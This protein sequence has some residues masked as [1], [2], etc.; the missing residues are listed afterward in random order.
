MLYRGHCFLHRAEVLGLL[1][2]WPE[3][4]DRGP[5]GL[6]SPGRSGQPRRP[7]RGACVI[8]GDL[9]RL[10]GDLDGAEAAYQ[11][12]SEHRP[13]PPAR[14]GAAATRP[15]AARR[16][17]RHDPSSPRR[18]PGPDRAGPPARR[19]TS[20]SCSP[21][22]TP[23][24]PRAAADEFRAMAAELG[25]PLLRAHAAARHRRRAAW[26]RATPSRRSSSCGGPSTS[27]TPSACAHDAARDPP[28]HRRRPATRSATTT[29]PRIESGAARAV[30]GVAR[31]VRDATTEASRPRAPDGLTRRELR[32]AP[33][34]SPE[35]RRTG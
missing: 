30:L 23:L 5:P 21:R 32:G 7:R 6:R 13:R 12:A 14:P 22:A 10:V 15:G 16:R 19:R 8:E 1:G 25:T 35:A 24:T 26:P 18:G 3:A 4:L 9:L 27:S 20:R 31:R 11:R 17:R 34:S 33:A 29:P 2:A 28:A